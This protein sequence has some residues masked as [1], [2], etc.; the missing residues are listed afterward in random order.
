MTMLRIVPRNR[1]WTTLLGSGI[2]GSARWLRS[3]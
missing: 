1:H 3:F 2:A